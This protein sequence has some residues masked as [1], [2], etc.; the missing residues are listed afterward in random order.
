MVVIILVC[1]RLIVIWRFTF[2]DQRL[3]V[4]FATQMQVKLVNTTLIVC[5][6]VL[7]QGQHVINVLRNLVPKRTGI[8]QSKH[9]ISVDVSSVVFGVLIYGKL[10]A[11]TV[12]IKRFQGVGLVV[13]NGCWVNLSDCF[14]RVAILAAI[15]VAAFFRI[16][17]AVITVFAIERF[18]ALAADKTIGGLAF[19]GLLA[20]CQYIAVGAL[21]VRNGDVGK[22][23]RRHALLWGITLMI[24][25]ILYAKMETVKST[26]IF[27]FRV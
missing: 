13:H 9:K 7:C 18:A 5:L 23:G 10:N 20:I 3:Q 11:Q 6:R 15:I 25:F 26:W 17:T 12:L 21:G 4:G 1:Q 8:F 2:I 19:A 14:F 22:W 24:E 27:L 16:L